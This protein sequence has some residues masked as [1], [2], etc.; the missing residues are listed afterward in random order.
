MGMHA[1]GQTADKRSA[2]ES[3]AYRQNNNR[4]ISASHEMREISF[5][6][7]NLGVNENG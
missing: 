4:A 1:R 5:D 3:L 2:C 7:E 6:R